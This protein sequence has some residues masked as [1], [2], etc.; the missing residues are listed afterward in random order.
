M[1][2]ER[3]IVGLDIGTSVIRVA[4]GE[5]D[6][7]GNLSVVATSSKKSAGLRNGVIVNI[8]DAKDIIKE[9]VDAAEQDGGVI[10]SSVIASVG[11]K[12]IESEN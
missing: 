1:A 12:Q 9:A 2:D 7:D 4:V 11:G 6:L 8:E 3:C 5:I 10:V